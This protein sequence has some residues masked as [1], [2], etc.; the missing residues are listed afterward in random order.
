MSEEKGSSSRKSVSKVGKSSHGTRVSHLSESPSSVSLKS[1]KRKYEIEVLANG[2]KF[3]VNKCGFSS[4][5]ETKIA[6]LCHMA[7]SHSVSQ[8]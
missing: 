3:A 2:K 8:K 1:I 4:L 5:S 6:D 7:L